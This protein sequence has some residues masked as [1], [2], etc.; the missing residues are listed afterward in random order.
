M[1]HG[2]A[3]T[4]SDLRPMGPHN[5]GIRRVPRRTSECI[6]LR[7]IAYGVI[8]VC[9]LG[10]AGAVIAQE[11]A[12]TLYGPD[13]GTARIITID[14][15]RDHEVVKISTTTPWTEGI[16][17]FVGIPVS[18]LLDGLSGTFE[19]A[20]TAIN[21]YTVT[22]PSSGIDPM[23]PVIAFERNGEAM[24]VRDKGPFW[25]I[26]PFDDSP[27]FRT[28]SMMSRSIWQLSK[29]EIVLPE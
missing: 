8:F 4:F 13:E 15:M 19:L 2:K 9:C 27:E 21:D 20:L 5:Q 18:A 26:Y 24:S 6:F 25:L 14:M 11:R 22:I 28:E 12:I 17:E 3:V 29:I 7:M 16:Q 10:F 1:G 23:V